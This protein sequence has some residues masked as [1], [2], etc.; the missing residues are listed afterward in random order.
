ME[1]AQS[2]AVFENCLFQLITV[3]RQDFN[4][5]WIS[6]G[7]YYYLLSWLFLRKVLYVLGRYKVRRT[8]SATNI[9]K[10]VCLLWPY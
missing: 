5:K 9:Q 10:K 8:I 7:K 3:H 1:S 6:S 2:G 4:D